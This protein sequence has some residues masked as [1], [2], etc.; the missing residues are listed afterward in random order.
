VTRI[1]RKCEWDRNKSVGLRLYDDY[2][3]DK[4]QVYTRLVTRKA[5]VLETLPFMY[6][7][8]RIRR[9]IQKFPD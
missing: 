6:L 4:R 2:D 7:M 8:K 5:A 9:C 1:G 3:N